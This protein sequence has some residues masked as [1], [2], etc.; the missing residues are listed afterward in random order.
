MAEQNPGGYPGSNKSEV[1]MTDPSWQLQ[2]AIKAALVA[3]ATIITLMGASPAVFDH[4]PDAE[5]M[6][7]IQLDEPGTSAWD[8][9]PTEADDGYGKEHTA[10]IH[11]WSSYEGKKEI[12]AIMRA[13]ELELRD[14]SP[15]LANHK[16]VNF[17]FQFADR[18]RDQDGQ[19]Y[20]GVIQFRAI[21]EEI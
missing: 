15:T 8:V 12:N 16:V 13:I 17:R 19:A 5:P 9:T 21:T 20:H 3:D 10:M 11:V 14:F 4:V 18:L 1:K 7:Y 2:K 6:P